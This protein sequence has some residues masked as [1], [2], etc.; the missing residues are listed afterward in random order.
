MRPLLEG[1]CAPL[2]LE[3]D[4]CLQR[5]ALLERCS[6]GRRR[7]TPFDCGRE[8]KDGCRVVAA[9]GRTRG[10]GGG[11]RPTRACAALYAALHSCLART[12]VLS[13]AQ[14]RLPRSRETWPP[15]SHFSLPLLPL[16]RHL[17][18]RDP[19][20][21]S[22]SPQPEAVHQLKAKNRLPGAGTECRAVHHLVFSISCR[23][24]L[25]PSFTR[26]IDDSIRHMVHASDSVEP[27][28]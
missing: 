11:F 23:A 7:S 27:P 10:I 12:S 3:G 4:L 28:A 18:L 20:T 2:L 1:R 14:Q 6:S 9:F 16:P 19:A 24:H 8:N 15:L 25:H 26:P 22:F 5:L 17:P 13:I 21:Q